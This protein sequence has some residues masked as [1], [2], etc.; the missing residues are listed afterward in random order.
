[1]DSSNKSSPKA[2]PQLIVNLL[3]LL[4]VGAALWFFFTNQP[5]SNTASSTASST[6]QATASDP[7]NR[8]IAVIQAQL[9]L[10]KARA[11]NVRVQ[12][13]I[14]QQQTQQT[15]PDTAEPEL[16][17]DEQ[18]QRI[19]KMIAAQSRGAERKNQKLSKA[20]EQK[21]QELAAAKT[22]NRQ[23]QNKIAAL[24]DRTQ[25][26]LAALD[27][28]RD[29]SDSD[30]NY[31]RALQGD[32]DNHGI[33]NRA[34]PANTATSDVDL[35][36]RIEVSDAQDT[37]SVS[38][39]LRNRISQLMQESSRPAPETTSPT[40]SQQPGDLQ[41]T[42]DALFDNREERAAERAAEKQFLA[43][44][45]YLESLDPIEAERSNETRW[46]TVRDGDTL[47]RIAQRVYNNADLYT[48]IYA[49]NPQVLSNPDLIRTG[50]RLRVPK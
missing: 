49:A 18:K 37:N 29:I 9:E 30:Q 20:L 24:D 28:G 26:L 12:L 19:A 3:L 46:V 45:Q 17:R 6:I 40:G 5:A 22:Q 10:E 13:R 41:S 34:R 4:L 21:E 8:D 2:R 33:S 15:Q 32:A 38:A 42:I 43:D 1:M 7:A 11:E 16:D 23:L 47:T 44:S 31:I 27:P 36:N 35:I 50:Q 48:K 39:Q 25:S 14:R